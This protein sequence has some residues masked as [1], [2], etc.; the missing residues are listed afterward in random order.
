MKL[1]PM[2]LSFEDPLNRF[3]KASWTS[4]D[5]PPYSVVDLL[6]EFPKIPPH[7]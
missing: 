3:W 7:G 6:F 4:F 5:M 2:T 1:L